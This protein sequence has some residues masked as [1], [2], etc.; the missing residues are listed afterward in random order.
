MA[1]PW[2]LLAGV[3]ATAPPGATPPMTENIE[4]T[5]VGDLDGVR[6]GMGNMTRGAYTK[7]DGSAANGLICSLAI[8]GAVGVFVGEGSEV[9][10]RG[11]TWVVTALEKSPGEPGSVTL[12]RK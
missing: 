9:A 1:A 3:L 12:R 10:V 5:T 4:E 8:D 11:A 6:V 7:A 2:L